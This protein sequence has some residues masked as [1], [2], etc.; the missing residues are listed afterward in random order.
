MTRYVAITFVLIYLWLDYAAK[1][2]RIVFTEPKHRKKPTGVSVPV[3]TNEKNFPVFSGNLD[4]NK[5]Q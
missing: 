5:T 1:N 4:Q 2:N 3:V